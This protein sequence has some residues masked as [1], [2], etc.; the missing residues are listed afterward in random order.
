MVTKMTS[1]E[2]GRDIPE[3]EQQIEHHQERKVKPT[4]QGVLR[5]Q[6]V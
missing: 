5:L 2:L 6:P 4:L 1:G 3:A